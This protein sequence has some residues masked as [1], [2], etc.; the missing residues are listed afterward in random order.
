MK[1]EDNLLQTKFYSPNIGEQAIPRPRL[2]QLIEKG[3]RKRLI[4]I[5]APAGYGK[6]SL[7]AGWL[8]EYQHRIAWLTLDEIDNDPNRFMDY[9]I[10]SLYWSLNSKLKKLIGENFKSKKGG[11]QQNINILLNCICD[12][13]EEV[14]IALDD[15]HNIHSPVIHNAINH[16]VDNSPANAHLILAT[17]SDPPLNLANWRAR[18]HLIEI[19]QA[20]LCFT[21]DETSLF[22]KNNLPSLFSEEEIIALDSKIEG[23]IAGMQ[24]AVSAISKHKDKKSIRQFIKSFKGTNRFILD[25]LMDEVLNN[26]PQD[27][28][29][30]LLY[31]SLID[32]FCAPLCDSVLKKNNSQELLDYLDR[33]NLFIIP[34]DNQRSWYRYH[35]L[36]AD[37]LK[38]QIDQSN[39][40]AEH[41]HAAAAEWFEAKE[42]YNEAIE[43]R[44][45]A[46][47]IQNA[48]RL[49]QSQAKY[50]LNRS[51]FFTFVNWIRRLPEEYLHDNPTL[52]AYYAITLI[53]E[54]R[55][56][57]EL[58]HILEIMEQMEDEAESRHTIVQVLVAIVQGNYTRAAE[59]IQMI[60]RNPPVEDGFLIGLLDIAQT[61]I[62]EGDIEATRNHLRETYRKAKLNGNMTIAVFSQCFLGD[63][64]LNKGKLTKAWETY[65]EAL[66]LANIGDG[67]YLPV[68]SIALLGMGEVA[69]RWNKL[70]EAEDY[71]QK[72]ILLAVNW[73]IIHFFSGLTSLARVQ[74][75]MGKNEEANESM[76]KAEELA[77]QFDTSEVDDF[78]VACRIIQLKLLMGEDDDAGELSDQFLFNAPQTNWKKNVLL[79]MLSLVQELQELTQAWV[80]LYKDQTSRAI[81]ILLNLYEQ[82]EKKGMVDYTIQYA[83]LL[84]IAYHKSGEKDRA[85]QY[86]GNALHL[87]KPEMQIRVFLEQGNDILELL[88][89]AARQGIEPEFTGKLLTLFPEMDSAKKDKEFL[90]LDGE[91]IE[92]LSGR[93]TEILTHIA[94]GL[95]NQQ[96]AYQLHLSL[97]TVK[98]HTYNIYRKLNVHNRT[99]A[100]AKANTLNIL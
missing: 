45:Q 2:T 15:F 31:T 63:I 16:F 54:G 96:I 86:I 70:E 44:F 11:I 52:C 4:L 48:A 36:F 18:D 84:A 14:I 30:F 76:Q 89:E 6:T 19:R 83:I 21:E 68:G 49:I 7:L 77:L 98:V 24:L 17:R 37:L 47:D 99:Q 22:F 64:H 62:F 85:M 9:F 12:S 8:E 42:L 74:I 95:S 38:S 5:S 43:H 100:V 91:I 57:Q 27:V 28:R 78:V 46:N 72:S 75:A 41:I 80:L 34:L 92:P 55:P 10:H 87:A 13:G 88:Y 59:Y 29:E 3:L 51:E 60:K 40:Q 56:F 94:Q 79:L 53:I 25:Y 32:H 61:I 23:W 66:E 33:R 82:S 20:D 93:E 65:N 71:F 58:K 90:H 39:S 97:S 50:V 35:R 69:Y 1:E 73:E 81:S 67:E 26:Q